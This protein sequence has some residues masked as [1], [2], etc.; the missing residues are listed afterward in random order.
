MVARMLKAVEL[1]SEKAADRDVKKAAREAERQAKALDKEA[2]RAKA[3]GLPLPATAKAL[4]QWGSALCYCCL[5]TVADPPCN[6]IA[7]LVCGHYL[8][9]YSKA[10]LSKNSLQLL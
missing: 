4:V 9:L 6:Q 7:I 10:A 2:A 1:R 5:F 3:A 8:S